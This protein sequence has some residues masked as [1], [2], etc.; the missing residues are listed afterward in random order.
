MTGDPTELVLMY[1][2]LPLWFC[3]GLADWA[4][5]RATDL[6]HTTGAKESLI[7]LLMFAEV[8]I[9][10]VMV[11][12]LEVN[13][14][15]IA[16]MIAAFLL[17]EATALWDVS[18]AVEHREVRPIEQHVHSFL[19]MVP[20]MALLL[21]VVRHW[22]Q[23]LAL[24]GLGSEPA[25]FVLEWKVR[26]LPVAYLAMVLAGAFVLEFVP[27]LQELWRALRAGTLSATLRRRPGS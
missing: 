17:H 8:G 15:I 9:P 22:D 23:F 27:Y 6:E 10:L 3:A 12:V 26:P 18:Y 13:A 21:V 2:V 14:L 24:V 25:R 7:H 11:L 20:L 1:F 4:C 5:H 16:V 19:E